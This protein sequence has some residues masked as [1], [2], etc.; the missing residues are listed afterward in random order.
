MLERGDFSPLLIYATPSPALLREGRQFRATS[1]SSRHRE[2][3]SW[4]KVQDIVNTPCQSYCLHR[5]QYGRKERTASASKGDRIVAAGGESSRDPQAHC[6][7]QCLVVQ[8][9]KALY[10][11]GVGRAQEFL[12]PSPSSE[13]SLPALSIWQGWLI[14]RTTLQWGIYSKSRLIITRLRKTPVK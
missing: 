10:P 1:Q 3:S 6:P 7:Q 14:F 12:P 5:R 9:A 11:N 2:Q 8:M 4:E 13:L